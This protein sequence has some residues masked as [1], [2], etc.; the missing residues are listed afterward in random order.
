MEPF[1]GRAAGIERLSRAAPPHGRLVS[2]P[3]AAAAASPT[4]TRLRKLRRSWERGAN[5]LVDSDTPTSTFEK[6]SW[7]GF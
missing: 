3:Y 2:T 1:R 5:E 7:E 6:T 4:A